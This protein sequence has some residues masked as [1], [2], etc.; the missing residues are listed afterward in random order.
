MWFVGICLAAV[1]G[2]QQY[3]DVPKDHWAHDAVMN[4]TAAG[5]INGMPDGTFRGDQ[6][7]TR[8]EFAV[9][10]DRFVRDVEKGLKEAPPSGQ[11]KEDEVGAATTHWAY[12]ALSHLYSAGY[13]PQGSPI[14]SPETKQITAAQLGKAL[15]QVATRIAALFSDP[16]ENEP[17]EE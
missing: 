16:R 5:Y 11:A 15:G 1:V 10:L 3:S 13:L 6:P 12:P 7:I 8:F 4:M 17:D 14:F 2:V 9:A